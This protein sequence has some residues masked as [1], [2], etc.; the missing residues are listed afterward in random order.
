VVVSGNVPAAPRPKVEFEITF[1]PGQSLHQGDVQ[2]RLLRLTG[3][4]KPLL[5]YARVIDPQGNI[6]YAYYPTQDPAPGEDLLLSP[7]ER[8]VYPQARRFPDTDWEWNETTLAVAGSGTWVWEMWVEDPDRPGDPLAYDLA[9][10]A[11]TPSQ[12]P[13]SSGQDAVGVIL[14][15]GLAVLLTTALYLLALSGH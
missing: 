13:A 1:T 3:S 14:A 8:S 6:G 9:A 15:I 7:T 10:Y 2:R 5:L 11:V 12:A 4:D